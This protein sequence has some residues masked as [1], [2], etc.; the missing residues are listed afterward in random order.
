MQFLRMKLKL[1]VE[2]FEPK[3]LRKIQLIYHADVWQGCGIL[4][5]V[6][7]SEGMNIL[8][9]YWPAIPTQKTF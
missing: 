1:W 8:D 4:I 9:V 2:T 7:G 3:Y 5:C 6:C